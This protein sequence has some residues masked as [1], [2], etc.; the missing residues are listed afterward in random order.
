MAQTIIPWYRRL[1]PNAE[2]FEV[3]GGVECIPDGAFNCHS[4]LR[5]VVIPVGVTR[6]GKYAFNYCTALTTVTIPFGVTTIKASTFFRCVSLQ[7]VTLPASVTC[8]EQG[9]FAQC[10]RLSRVTFLSPH[11]KLGNYV[12]S[13][14]GRLQRVDFSHFLQCEP[15]FAFAGCVDVKLI[16]QNAVRVRV[17]ALLCMLRQSLRGGNEIC[18]THIIPFLLNPENILMYSIPCP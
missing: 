15:Q 18:R 14:C 2:E 3:P 5:T 6:I 12:F 1:S 17:Y 13:E 8:V 10:S 16:S 11:V 4:C 7:Y 9:A